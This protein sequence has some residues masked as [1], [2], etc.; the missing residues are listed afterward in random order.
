MWDIGSNVGIY[1]IYAAKTL[2][3]SVYA[4]EPS[5]FNI[6]TLT[7]NVIL[8]N[9]ESKISIIP[10]AVSN[11]QKVNFLNMSNTIKSGSMSAFGVDFGYDGKKIINEIKYKILGLSLD[12]MLKNLNLEQPDY[13]KIDVDGIEHIILSDAKDVLLNTKSIL[14]EINDDFADQRENCENILKKN[15]FYLFKK[16]KGELTKNSNFKNSFNQIWVKK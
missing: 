16:E 2:C 14:I 4:F 8:N 6:E 12:F 9:L 3:K 5:V 13:I 15:G 10:I 1:S 7:R 11:N